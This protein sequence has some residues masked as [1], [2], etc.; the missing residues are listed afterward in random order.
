M[1]KT[2][3]D[4]VDITEMRERDKQIFKLRF[5]LNK[6]KEILTLDAIGGMFGVG[7]ERVRQ[8]EAR[9]IAYIRSRMVEDGFSWEDA[10]KKIKDFRICSRKELLRNGLTKNK[11]KH[12]IEEYEDIVELVKKDIRNG[13]KI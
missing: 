2:I 10:S 12:F 8:I 3:K 4:Y 7:R 11:V 6:N 9:A 1:E 5:G 13:R